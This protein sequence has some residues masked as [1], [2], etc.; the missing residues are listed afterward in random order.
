MSLALLVLASTLAADASGVELTGTI[1]DAE[2]KP[3][4]GARVL[5]YAAGPRRGSSPL[6]PYCYVDCSKQAQTNAQGT[7]S[8]A[9]LSP[10]LVFQVLIVSERHQPK[11]VSKVDP[12]QKRLEARLVAVAADVDPQQTVFGRVVNAAGEPIA[13]ATI[14]PF[15][16]AQKDRHQYGGLTARGVDTLAVSNA[17]GEFVIRGIPA[18][19][20]LDASV[21]AR[22]FATQKLQQ[23]APGKPQEIVLR[24]GATIRGS[25]T[26]AGQP[27]PGVSL[28][29]A[30]TDRS[31]GTFKGHFEIG[32]D[33]RGGFEFRHVPPDAEYYLYSKIDGR[34]ERGALPVFQFPVGQ[35]DTVSDVGALA[36]EPAYRL[37]GRVMSL[38]G[39][40]LPD[41]T[42][43][44]L[45]RS[46]AW[47]YQTVPIG[48]DGRFEFL[49]VPPE[50]LELIVRVKG[51]RFVPGRN[52]FQ[53]TEK[54][55][56]SLFVEKNYEDVWIY[57]QPDPNAGDRR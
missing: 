5:I 30:H 27:A 11:L 37:A 31:A 57:L 46:R 17:Q 19:A 1:A 33:E 13:E 53:Q 51:Y 49:G 7:F 12:T 55:T 44:M 50:A 28:G 39:K 15:G 35:D 16:L 38:D 4:A 26:R 34:E 47:D 41:G 2:G 52:R 42:Q 9:Q 43:L 45:S 48:A 54:S 32:T 36:L 22:E 18:D 20:T 40:P 24:K 6:C 3:V 23:L 8:I 14:E 29:I 25:V 10:E 21:S 56:L